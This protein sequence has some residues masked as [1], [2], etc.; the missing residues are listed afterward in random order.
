MY[1]I[2]RNFGGAKLWRMFSPE[3]LEGESL[4]NQHAF[5]IIFNAVQFR[6]HVNNEIATVF[7]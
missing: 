2:A 7:T 4:A 5:T 3:H 6:N 1:C